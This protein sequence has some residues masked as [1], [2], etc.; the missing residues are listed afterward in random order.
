MEAMRARE[1]SSQIYTQGL[2]DQLATLG[3]ERD[4]LQAEDTLAQSEASLRL[5]LVGLYKALGGGWELPR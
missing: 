2:A 5:D 4:L 1:V 3:A